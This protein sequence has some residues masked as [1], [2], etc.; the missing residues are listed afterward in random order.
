MAAVTNP[1]LRVGGID[2]LNALPLTRYLEADGEP[3]LDVT[4]HPPSVLASKLRAGL[5]DVALVPVVEYLARPDYRIVPGPCIASYGEVRSIRLY[6]RQPLAAA[7]T[8]LLDSS[9]RTSSALTRLL[10][11]DLWGGAPRFVDA[12]PLVAAATLCGAATQEGEADAVLLIG[13]AALETASPHGWDMVDLGT[14]WTSWTGLP[15][16]YAFW[17]WKGGDAPAGLTAKLERARRLGQ[18][19]VDDIVREAPLPAGLDAAAARHYLARVIQYDLAP[20]QIEGLQ[21]FFARIGAAAGTPGDAHARSLEW[22]EE[23]RL[24]PAS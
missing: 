23:P 12:S 15:F 20:P 1:P 18:A 14:A 10:F 9:S 3:P 2:Y 13:D 21:E 24:Q 17:L 5:L 7:R 8:V 16:V 11:R 19:R 4:D 6:H 22:L